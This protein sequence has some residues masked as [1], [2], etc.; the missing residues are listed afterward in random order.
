MNFALSQRRTDRH[1]V[2]LIVVVGLH[3]LLAGVLLS[4]KLAK[5]P[6]GRSRSR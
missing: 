6:A 4:A 1:P 2:G 5:T 3:V